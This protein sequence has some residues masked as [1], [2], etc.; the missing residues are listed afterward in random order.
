MLN[1]G[2]LDGN[3]LSISS[4]A[5]DAPHEDA[6]HQHHEGEDIDQEAKPRSAVLAELLAHG[7]QLSDNAL[8]K[9]IAVDGTVSL[10]LHEQQHFK[11]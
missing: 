11:V 7:Y 3:S 8:E 1:G 6:S 9:A 5:G 4:A 2:T 10:F